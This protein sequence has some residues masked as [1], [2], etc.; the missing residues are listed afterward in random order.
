MLFMSIGISGVVMRRTDAPLLQLPANLS[1]HIA[2][3]TQYGF[4][5]YAEPSLHQQPANK[6][7]FVYKS[8]QSKNQKYKRQNHR[9]N[10]IVEVE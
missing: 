6:L 5:R 1:A 8:Q 4:I 3:S 10:T 9:S 2:F 7:T